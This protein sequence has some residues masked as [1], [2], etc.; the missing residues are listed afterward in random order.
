MFGA[1]VAVVRGVG[2]SP[3]A[4]AVE[5]DE[6]EAGHA[7]GAR[8][9]APRRHAPA[10]PGMGFAVDP[11]QMGR[12][13]VR[14]DLGGG[15]IG[16]AEHLLDGAQVGASLEQVGGERVPE[17]VGGDVVGQAGL[18]RVALDDGVKSLAG[19][20]PAAVVQ[21]QLRRLEGARAAQERAAPLVVGAD[22]LD[23]HAPQR[24]D[25]LL[26]ALADGADEPH[27]QVDVLEPQSRGPPRPAGRRRRASRAA[28]GRAARRASPSAWTAAA[29]P[30]PPSASRGSV[31]SSRGLASARVGSDSA[32]PS[33][34]RRR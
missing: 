3:D 28:P 32:S 27:L 2:Q 22:G 10:G 4:H 11:L 34:T 24:D 25:A 18:P 9:S 1:G 31:D 7:R 33:T 17:G 13:H 8:H 30:P 6:H 29:R 14:V 12:G 16:V 19:Q 21:E 15:E 20:P 23:G 5:H 26:V